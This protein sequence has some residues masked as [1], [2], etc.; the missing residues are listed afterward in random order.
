MTFPPRSSCNAPRAL[1][2]QLVSKGVRVLAGED[3]GIGVTYGISLHGELSLMVEYGMSPVEALRSATSTAASAY[4][5]TDRGVIAP[6]YIAD[7]LLVD[8]DP[9]TDLTDLRNIISVWTRGFAVS[10]QRF[11]D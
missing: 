8:G 1:L 9:T 7:L 3:S 4:R 11:S 2:P 5:L 10:R 6:G